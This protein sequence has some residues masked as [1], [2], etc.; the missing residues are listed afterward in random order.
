MNYVISKF[1]NNIDLLSILIILLPISIIIGNLA[2]NLS[3]LLIIILGVKK[4]NQEFIKYLNLFKFYLIVLFFFFILNIIF[5][6]DYIFSL[7]GI[8]GIIRYILLSLIIFFWLNNNKN[9]L[10]IFLV[11]IFFCIV[12]VAASIYIEFLIKLFY[13]P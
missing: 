4:F 6:S 10:F 2:I 9:N 5:S 7:K 3:C 12:L 8:L 1:K 13:Y 11:S